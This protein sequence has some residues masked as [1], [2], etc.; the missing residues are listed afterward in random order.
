MR[1]ACLGLTDRG[2][3]KVYIIEPRRSS[4]SD[5][6][7]GFPR[8]LEFVAQKSGDPFCEYKPMGKRP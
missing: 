2:T 5:A 6:T 3:H 8:R 7:G 1:L 4:V